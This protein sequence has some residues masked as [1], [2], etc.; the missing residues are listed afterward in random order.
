[1]FKIAV[2]AHD[3]DNILEFETQD[4]YGVL[5]LAKESEIVVDKVGTFNYESHKW[6]NYKEN[7]NYVQQLLIYVK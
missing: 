1:M 7:N 4:V 5:N 6:N 2:I 3:D